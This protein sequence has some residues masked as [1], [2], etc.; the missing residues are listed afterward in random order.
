MG[1]STAVEGDDNALKH[2]KAVTSTLMME[3]DKSPKR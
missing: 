1:R 2:T 3:G